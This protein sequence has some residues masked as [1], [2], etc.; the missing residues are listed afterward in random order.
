MAYRRVLPDQARGLLNYP[1]GLRRSDSPTLSWIGG[2]PCTPPRRPPLC[3]RS[4]ASSVS[5]Y[6]KA[7]ASP[8]RSASGAKAGAWLAPPRSLASFF[9]RP[10]LAVAPVHPSV[11]RR[12]AS[13]HPR[14]FGSPALVPRL[15]D[16]APP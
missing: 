16:A 5:A 2:V 15:T 9:L 14:S 11:R 7:T 1:E 12:V 6:A 4:A 13:A 10:C 3:W 8:R